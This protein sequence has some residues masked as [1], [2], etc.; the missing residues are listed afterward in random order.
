MKKFKILSDFEKSQIVAYKGCGLSNR[1][2][3]LKLGRHHSSIGSFLKKYKSSG[4]FQ[5]KEGTGKKKN[6]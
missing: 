1:A 6:D 5:R 3:G 2:I 4:E